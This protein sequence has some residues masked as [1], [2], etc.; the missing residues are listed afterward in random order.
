LRTLR[1]EPPDAQRAAGSQR[2]SALRP[3]VGFKPAPPRNADGLKASVLAGHPGCTPADG[4]AGVTNSGSCHAHTVNPRPTDA[5]GK[6]DL[7]DHAIRLRNRRRCHSLRRRCNRSGEASNSN[8]PNH[9]APPL[10]AL[11]LGPVTELGWCGSHVQAT[12]HYGLRAPVA[13][14]LE[15]YQDPYDSFENRAPVND[16]RAGGSDRCRFRP[17]LVGVA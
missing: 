5:A 7:R 11:S 15:I 13:R 2:L 16:R 3:C 17:T 10:T 9:S 12:P 6:S 14:R 1:T 4:A 8:Q